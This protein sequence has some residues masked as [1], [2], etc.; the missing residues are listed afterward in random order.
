MIFNGEFFREMYISLSIC[1]RFCFL[2][3]EA[4][5]TFLSQHKIVK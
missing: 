5:T 3:N 1:H 2:L 4:V